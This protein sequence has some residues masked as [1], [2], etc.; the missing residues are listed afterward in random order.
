MIAI[1][2]SSNQKQYNELQTSRVRIQNLS[3]S[4]T[5]V[6]GW[7]KSYC[8]TPVITPAVTNNS[9]LIYLGN[10]SENIPTYLSASSIH[11]VQNSRWEYVIANK[12]YIA[13][14]ITECNSKDVMITALA[15]LNEL[16][17]IY[18]EDT[19]VTQD[20]EWKTPGI[21]IQGNL[22]LVLIKSVDTVCQKQ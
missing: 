3:I 8:A 1:T 14:Y 22:G 4:R 10:I 7:L 21:D 5:N 6:D 12:A 9:N 13:S 2:P 16:G 11:R 20:R 17:E 15:F 19:I 18:Y